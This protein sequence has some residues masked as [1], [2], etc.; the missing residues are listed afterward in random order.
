[1]DDNENTTYEN[2]WNAALVMH[3]RKCI[4]LN[5]YTGKEERWKIND[6]WLNFKK[7]E[8]QKIKLRLSLQKEMIKLRA[9]IKE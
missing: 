6:L 4:G 7:L 9:K 2:L 3:R 5:A 8:G 1:M